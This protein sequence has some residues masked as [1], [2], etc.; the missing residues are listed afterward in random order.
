MCHIDVMIDYIGSLDMAEI[1][2]I[3]V[4]LLLCFCMGEVILGF[5]GLIRP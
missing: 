4:I 1:L 2:I 3:I 5:I